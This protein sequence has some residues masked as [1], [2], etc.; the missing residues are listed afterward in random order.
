[1][2]A[3]PIELELRPM[4]ESD[5]N[6]ILSSWLRS[7]AGKGLDARD[8]A[9]HSRFYLD[10][11]PVVRA[12]CERSQ[13]IVACMPDASD[14]V[15]GWMAIEGDALHYVC[16]KPRWR[17]LGVARWMLQDY[18]RSPA[19][20]THRTTDAMRCRIPAAWEYRRWRVWPAEGTAA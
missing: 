8:Y 16:V 2:S 12:L 18:A 9:E 1:M 15:I 4:R 14:V 6:Y 19:V 5:R 20:F 7:Y 13:V 3:P 17:R 11:A 10:Y